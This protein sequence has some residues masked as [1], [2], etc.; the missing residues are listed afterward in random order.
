M[1]A[2]KTI[3]LAVLIATV[4]ALS[5]KKKTE[6]P[7]PKQ[8]LPLETQQG[9][10][11]FGCKVDGNVFKSISDDSLINNNCLRAFGRPKKYF[12]IIATG[13]IQ[14][15]G[16]Y[17]ES[18]FNFY[19]DNVTGSGKYILENFAQY[20]SS[21]NHNDF[22]INYFVTDSVHTGEVTVT[23]LDTVNK[24]LSGTFVMQ[25]AKL[26]EVQSE[27]VTEGRFDVTYKTP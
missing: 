3:A 14:I 25:L 27:M 11:T 26:F 15:G 4:L 17:Q 10:N 7:V 1:K 19:L 24:I 8:Q 18:Q 5:C 2:T 22:G 9:M 6:Q 23:K 20:K 13:N 12:R 16:K 21:A